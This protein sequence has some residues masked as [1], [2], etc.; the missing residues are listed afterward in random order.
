MCKKI[1][2]DINGTLLKKK[3]AYSLLRTTII[4]MSWWNSRHQNNYHKSY[5]QETVL[6]VL[7]DKND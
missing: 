7:I 2:D 5:T 6:M 3:A 4:K 1:K